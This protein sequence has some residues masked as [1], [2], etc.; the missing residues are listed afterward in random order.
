[1]FGFASENSLSK[2]YLDIS[3]LPM[4]LDIILSENE[5]RRSSG[6]NISSSVSSDSRSS[7][8]IPKLPRER[9]WVL[10]IPSSSTISSSSESS[11]S[12]SIVSSILLRFSS[13]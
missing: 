9:V 6:E 2:A 4:Q 1:M 11:L 13:E 8:D 5:R 7:K 12:S 10:A 3:L